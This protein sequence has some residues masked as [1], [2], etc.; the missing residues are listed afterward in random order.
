MLNAANA[1]RLFYGGFHPPE[2]QSSPEWKED[3]NNAVAYEGLRQKWDK[4]EELFASGDA[5]N[6]KW[7]YAT[8]HG[9]YGSSYVGVYGAI[10]KETNQKYILQLDCLATDVFAKD[11]YPTY[12]YFNPY[13]T[14]KLVNIDLPDG[15]FDIYETRSN[16]FFAK[17]VSGSSKLKLP[18]NS[19]I[20]IV[21]A[22]AKGKLSK[23]GHKTLING[24]T[25]DY[26]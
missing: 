2:R 12:L 7:G 13:K 20:I 25:V 4:D 1:S 3:K 26:R 15:S 22:P 5:V 10:I 8:D 9:L 24:V 19:S 6:H 11:A 23:D 14:E 16:R 21:L 17:D 18:A